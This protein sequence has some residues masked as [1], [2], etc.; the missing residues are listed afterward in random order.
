MSMQ[1]DAEFKE[2]QLGTPFVWVGALEGGFGGG[3]G[4]SGGSSPKSI[5]ACPKIKTPPAGIELLPCVCSQLRFIL[6]SFSSCYSDPFAPSLL[7]F[8]SLFSKLQRTRKEKI[9][10]AA[11]VACLWSVASFPVICGDNSHLHT[12][13]TY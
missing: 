7:V 12:L 2:E 3:S 1:M 11:N 5:H 13:D 10:Q 9:T 6:I 8:C 4:G